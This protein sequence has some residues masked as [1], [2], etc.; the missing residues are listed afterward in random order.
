MGR[1][2]LPTRVSAAD[3]DFLNRNRAVL[4]AQFDPACDGK[5]VGSGLVQR[6]TDPITGAGGYVAIEFDGRTAI[7]DDEIKPAVAVEVSEGAASGAFCGC[8]ASNVSCFAKSSIGVLDQQVV[9]VFHRIAGHLIDIAFGDE[10]V[11]AGVVIYVAELRV[12][13]G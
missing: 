4:C 9:R 6:D 12:P 1:A 8:D 13:A 10:E 5:S 11:R 2:V 3:C 7:Y